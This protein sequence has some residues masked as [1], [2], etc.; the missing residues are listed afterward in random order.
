MKTNP[1]RA[2]S[3][4]RIANSSA[5]SDTGVP[6][7][8]GDMR[9][10]VDRKAAMAAWSS[11]ACRRRRRVP[12]PPQ[13]RIDPRHQFARAERL[14]DVIV[15]ADLEAEDAINLLVAGR[16][17]QD[18]RI[19]GL[20]DL[21]ADLQAVH[22]RHADIEHDQLVDAAVEQPQRFLAVLRGGDRH[23]GLFEREAD[24]VADMRIVVD[25]ENGMQ[26]CRA[27]LCRCPAVVKGSAVREEC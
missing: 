20:A 19:R 17:K 10:Q 3:V 1:G 8:A 26:P 6:G 21:P 27:S 5:V 12:C 9:I 15:A 13:D 11:L 25:D 7:E 18:R 4:R 2:S 14:G 24:D 23:A 16:Q 22:L